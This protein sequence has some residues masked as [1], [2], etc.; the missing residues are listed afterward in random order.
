MMTWDGLTS[1]F[2]VYTSLAPS[3]SR[4]CSWSSVT[5]LWPWQNNHSLFH[6]IQVRVD[7]DPMP[8]TLDM[9]LEHTLDGMPIHSRASCKHIVF[10]YS[11]TSR[12]DLSE[13]V[14]LLEWFWEMEETHPQLWQKVYTGSHLS[15]ELNPGSVRQRGY[16]PPHHQLKSSTWMIRTLN[17]IQF[18]QTVFNI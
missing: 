10:T 17:E 15:L 4:I 7:S 18:C 2:R 12:C 14:H 8:G 9:K 3:V 1:P 6:L 16:T 11:Y 5:Q 13:L